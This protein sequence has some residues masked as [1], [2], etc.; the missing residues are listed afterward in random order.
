MTDESNAGLKC[1]LLLHAGNEMGYTAR[2][3]LLSPPNHCSL[4]LGG[5]SFYANSRVTLSHHSN[6]LAACPP[7]LAASTCRSFRTLARR[8]HGTM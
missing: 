2:P 6:S 8:P 3:K 7:S 4:G 1:L 5:V